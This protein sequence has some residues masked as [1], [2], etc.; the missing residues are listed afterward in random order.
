MLLLITEWCLPTH[1]F[2]HTAIS[3]LLRQKRLLGHK[4]AFPASTPQPETSPRYTFF[5]HVSA[6]CS[7]RAN[8]WSRVRL[9]WA[10]Y[11]GVLTMSESQPIESIEYT[12]LKRAETYAHTQLSC[13]AEH[14]FSPCGDSSC[15]AHLLDHRQ[16][17]GQELFSATDRFGIA[18][19]GRS[20]RKPV[21]ALTKVAPPRQQASSPL[22]S[23]VMANGLFGSNS[24][25]PH[26]AMQWRTLPSLS[27]IWTT[28]C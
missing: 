2:E 12:R 22:A 16:R 4:N 14:S 27:S 20:S 9:A 8:R 26:A 25:P 3:L 21:Y 17:V 19:A 5:I 7:A 6:S 28:Q 10:R 23:R 11:K 24:Q 15:L 1:L 18:F 13:K